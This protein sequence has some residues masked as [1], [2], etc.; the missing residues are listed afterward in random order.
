[1]N[2]KTNDTPSLQHIKSA[3]Y[4]VNRHAKTALDSR[5]LY[6]LK[7]KTLKKLVE[8]NLAEKICL[9]YSLNPS[10]GFQ[11]SVVL[12]RVGHSKSKEPFYF[13][14]IAEKSDF[15]LEHKGKINQSIQNPRVQMALVTAKSILYKYLGETPKQKKTSHKNKNKKLE[16]VFVSSYLDGRKRF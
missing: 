16:S 8:E 5:E 2:T 1:M 10:K 6:Y 9:E 7:R 13:H 11:S 15:K 3:L 14:T 12:V 4:T